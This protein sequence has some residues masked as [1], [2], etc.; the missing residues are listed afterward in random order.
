MRI[1]TLQF[2]PKLGDVEGNIRRAEEL[3]KRGTRRNGRDRDGV[4][5]VGGDGGGCGIEELR[6]EILVLPELAFTGGFHPSSLPIITIPS[7]EGLSI[8]F[9]TSGSTVYNV[10]PVP[11]YTM[12]LIFAL[13]F[14]AT[15]LVSGA[16]R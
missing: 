3:L 8:L 4:E 10:F 11:C 2:A 1:A 14:L 9:W 7:Q 16:L 13:C 12:R 6:P 15:S 5:A